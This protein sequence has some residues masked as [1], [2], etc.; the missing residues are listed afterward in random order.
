MVL[1]LNM[2]QTALNRQLNC[3]SIINATYG[4]IN[5]INNFLNFAAPNFLYELRE[6]PV[7]ETDWNGPGWS[8]IDGPFFGIMPF[9]FSKI[10]YF[11]MLSYL[12]WN[13]L[14]ASL[15]ILKYD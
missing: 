9:G 2:N 15:L 4:A 8:V 11:M 12:Y 14:S 5:Y 10:I 13:G 6:V 1:R 7:V 3:S